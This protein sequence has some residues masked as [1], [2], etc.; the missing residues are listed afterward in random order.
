LTSRT[1]RSRAGLAGPGDRPGAASP[2]AI[3][4]KVQ[5]AIGPLFDR[6]VLDP[7]TFV[8]ED[9]DSGV[10]AG[11]GGNRRDA[12]KRYG[13]DGQQGEGTHGNSLERRMAGTPQTWHLIAESLVCKRPLMS[14]ELFGQPA[15]CGQ[16]LQPDR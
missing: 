5:G 12:T 10:E 16:P 7:F 13:K 4:I 1:N 15:A 3:A 2:D 11:A 14:P 6:C 9:D 8:T